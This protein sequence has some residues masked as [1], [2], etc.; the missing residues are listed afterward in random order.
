MHFPASEPN[1]V[2]LTARIVEID[3]YDL[4]RPTSLVPNHRADHEFE[5]LHARRC[6]L[7]NPIQ[8]PLLGKAFKELF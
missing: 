5:L 6:R 1:R 8:L 2:R 7:Y 4:P 3:V